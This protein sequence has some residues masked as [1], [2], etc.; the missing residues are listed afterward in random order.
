[1]KLFGKKGENVEVKSEKKEEEGG[2]KREVRRD[3]PEPA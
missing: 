1:M 3:Q 2:Q